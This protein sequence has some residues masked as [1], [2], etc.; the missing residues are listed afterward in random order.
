MDSL[1]TVDLLITGADVVTPDGVQRRDLAV[2]DGRIAALVDPDGDAHPPAATRLDGRGLTVLPGLI[3][4]HV[5]F[6]TPGLTD[7]ETWATGSRAAVAGGVTTVIDMPNTRP[8]LFRPADA[9]HREALISGQSL[10]D[11]RFHAGIDP[12]AVHLLAEF[13]PAEATSAKG[14]L[15]GHH[16]AP[17]VI[18]DPKALEQ[19]FTVAADTGLRLLFHAEDDG[20]FQLL[21]GWRGVPRQYTDYEPHRPRSGAIVAVSRLI[22]LAR[23]HGTPVHVLHVSSREEVDLLSAARAAGI[24]VTF[25]V[26]GHHLSF[27]AADTRSLGARIRLSPA[28][29]EPADRDRLWEAVLD[30]TAATVGSD[31]APHAL[32]D[33][34]RPVADA[35]PGLPGVQELLPALFTGLRR[36]L[37]GRPVHDLLTTVARLL[38]AT[39]AELFGLAPAKGRIAVGADADLVLFDPEA[40]WT[41]GP[42][43]IQARVGWSAYQGWT[44]TG[45]PVLTIRGGTV[46]YDGRD[47]T[48]RFGDPTGRWLRPPVPVA[49]ANA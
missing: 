3:D 34:Q 5:H 20:I 12:T 29:R 9:H 15:A 42:E 10:V 49:T 36:R 21:D 32:V 24:P 25:E 18:R 45:R 2:H 39:P 1:T 30:G 28:I 4:S 40:T 16:T 26:T 44:F 38:A 37:P 35:P 46:V 11:Y 19:A 8:P 7:K 41:L 27:T 31:H 33:K 6:R 17:H 47:E 14:F 43:Q 22:E 48:P 23:R 13:T